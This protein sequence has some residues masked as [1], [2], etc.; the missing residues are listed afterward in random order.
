MQSQELIVN[1]QQ[2]DGDG[3]PGH[4]D[5][6]ITETSKPALKRPSLYR[7]VMLNDD[8]TPMDFVVEVLMSFFA[9]SEEKATQVMLTV[10]TEG[11]AVCGVY[12]RDIAETKAAQ[13]NQYAAECQH[14]LLCEL[15]RAD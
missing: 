7:V 4:G 15:E 14:P 10:H 6:V 2:Q 11:K 3:E 13:V 8:F 12:T 5:H 9:L 1:T